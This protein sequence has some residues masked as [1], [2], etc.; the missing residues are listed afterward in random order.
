M[1]EYLAGWNNFNVA[2]MGAAGALAGLVIVAASVN[3]AEVVKA[4][5]LTS[6][7]AGDIAGL[8]LALSGSAVG[9]VPEVSP[10]SYG[11]SMAVLTAGAGLL[12][13]QATRR[14]YEN[15][16]PDNQMKFGKSAV[17][18]V[19]PFAYLVGAALLITGSPQ[20]V[21]WFAAGSIVAIIT[22]LVISWIALV[23]VLR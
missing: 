10:M 8:V 16:H 4:P 9:L 3:I 1:E 20:G 18:F 6:R 11:L 23:E 2:I 15:R 7:L 21:V 14:I 5:S 19:A 22:A 17:G 13:V 12:Q